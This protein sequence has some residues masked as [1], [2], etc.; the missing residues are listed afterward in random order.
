MKRFVFTLTLLLSVTTWAYAQVVHIPDPNLREALREALEL[1]DGEPITRQAMLKLTALDVARRGIEN[2]TG[3]QFATNLTWLALPYNHMTDLTAVASLKKLELLYMWGTPVTDISPLS[4]LTKLKI[5]HGSYS[6]ISDISPLA[7]VFALEQLFLPGNGI[8]DIKAL[9][10]LSQL[11][12][13]NLDN[14]S[15]TDISP[16][17]G[18]VEL[19]TLSL[20]NNLITDYSA[21][22]GLSLDN[23]TRDLAP[24]DMPP[25]PLEPRLDNR[26]FPSLF[27]GWSD[28]KIWA[29]Y[30]LIWCC[31]RFD[32]RHRERENDLLI[33]TRHSSWDE[34]IAVRD[35]Y[36]QDNPKMV[37]L[38][39]MR[40]VWNDLDRFSPDSSYWLRDENG[41]I[42]PAWDYGVM[43]LNDPGWQ[44]WVI[45]RAATINKCGLYDGIMIDGWAEPSHERVGLVPGQVAIL[46]GIRE[47]VRDDFL[48][49]VNTNDHQ[50]P[51]SAPYINGLFMETVFPWRSRHTPEDIEWRLTKIEN[52]LKWAEQTVREPRSTL[53]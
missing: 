25:L 50:S 52:T 35:A 29:S 4:H 38:T 37:F 22:D 45:N 10:N 33:H 28:G 18:L 32:T 3:L 42:M 36:L 46:Q 11:N 16:L 44:E 21:L 43:N 27:T 41:E 24:C 8:T 19:K 2:L 51:A 40:V 12:I 53:R 48:I 9:A 47:R 1:P 15:I 6:R 23:V 49:L 39:E 30:D 17:A 13:L 31:P 14:N 5:F 34:S 20:K 7:R 26:A